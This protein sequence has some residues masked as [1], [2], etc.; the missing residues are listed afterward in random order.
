MDKINHFYKTH[1]S[2]QY[3][4]LLLLSII[5]GV[6]WYLLLYGRHTLYFSNVQWIYNAGG[7]LF[8]HQLG[9]E[10]FRQEPWRFPLGRLENYGYPYGT[11]LTFLDSIPLFAIPFKL[12]SPILSKHFQYLGIWELSSIIGLL[13]FGL[14]ILKEFTPSIN[15]NIIGASLLVLS[16]P[17]LYRVF[18]HDSL[19]AQWI[20][21]A[22]IWFVI[23]EYRHKLWR[24]AWLVLFTAAILV[25]LYFVAMLIPL[26][27]VSLFF[28][29]KREKV[30][31]GLLFDV[32]L[33]LSVLL[34]IGYCT[35]CF[36]LSIN[37]LGR[38]EYGSFS[39]NANG[40][41]N[42]LSYSSILNKMS[43]GIPEQYEGFSYLGLGN[44]L[45]FLIAFLIYFQKDFSS[46]HLHFLLPV[47][48]ISL[49]YA[50]F[51]LSNRA[52]IN[53]QIIWNI[54]LPEFIN[55][56]CSMFR[57]SGRFIW[58]V[59]YLLVLF[60][61]I[62]INRNIK[63]STPLLILALLI[64]LV[65][66]QPLYT[67]KNFRGFSVY[68]SPMQAEFWQAAAES[69]KHIIILPATDEAQSVYQPIAAYAL[70]NE[71]TLNWG[72][73]A[74]ADYISIEKDGDQ[75]WND[76]LN[77]KSDDQTLYFLWTP[78]YI[79]LAKEVLS[80]KMLVCE[81]DGFSLVLSKNNRIIESN[82]GLSNY[83][84]QN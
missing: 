46:R 44:L 75:I 76:L 84:S 9:W 51:A 67:S 73:F 22:A 28:R 72:Y 34:V 66:I 48:F 18:L 2:I 60:G 26:W 55:T 77:N 1:R 15:K 37:V 41:I 40:F 83:C 59:F 6:L 24:G 70:Q 45:L 57:S 33:V 8:Q 68:Q 30:K 64:Q 61:V 38:Y 7:D 32:F 10:W 74:R 21:L 35:G 65:D 62:I 20:I 25:H 36:S 17:L 58:A 29:Y 56:L 80:T 31:W 19:S 81:I 52:F 63:Y 13:F 27:G 53:N 16:P 54:Q 79:E 4:S 43:L 47:L 69:N 12:L 11:N 78:E 42:P 49:L 5:I 50:L 39:W 14:L 82:I 3:L 23:L 71:M